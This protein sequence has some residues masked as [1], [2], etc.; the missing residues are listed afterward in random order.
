ME[1]PQLAEGGMV[2][3]GNW[4]NGTKQSAETAEYRQIT[5]ETRP[6]IQTFSDRD[7]ESTIHRH[8]RKRVTQGIKNVYK[9][10]LFSHRK[11]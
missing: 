7:S 2:S 10:I 5:T 9:G 6:E 8:H 4:K 1:T 3:E 11:E